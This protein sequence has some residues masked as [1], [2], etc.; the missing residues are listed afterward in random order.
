MPDITVTELPDFGTSVLTAVGVPH[1]DAYF[2]AISFAGA[3]LRGHDC[4]GTMRLFQYVGFI[5]RGEIRIGVDLRVEQET[6]AVVVPDGQWGFGQ[7]QAQWLLDLIFPKAWALGVAVGAARECEHVGRLGESAER[8]LAEGFTL[9]ATV[10]NCRGL[11]RVDPPAESSR[12]SERTRFAHRCPRKPRCP[13]RGRLQHERRRGDQ[14]ARML[15]QS[16]RGASRMAAGPQRPADPAVL[17]ENPMGTILPLGGAQSFEGFRLSLI[18]A[19]WA[20]SLSRGPCSHPEARAKGGNNMLFIALVN[21]PAANSSR[22]RRPCSSITSERRPALPALRRSCFLAIQRSA[23]SK[24]ARTVGFPSTKK[25]LEPT[26]QL[27]AP[28]A[29][30]A[31]ASM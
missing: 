3:N 11:K 31:F 19:L 2:V 21:L 24:P 12:A 27:R 18:M 23:P 30:R 4:H 20:G 17:D 16:A 6:P 22:P 10:N 29:S 7:I 14:S 9:L 13:N 1:D 15:C 8:T 26:F 28:S 5:E 25:A